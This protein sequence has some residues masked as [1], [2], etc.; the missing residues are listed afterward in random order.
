MMNLYLNVIILS[1]CLFISCESKVD[2][3]CK[4]QITY[5]LLE[6]DIEKARI[7]DLRGPQPI[8]I[9]PPLLWVYLHDKYILTLDDDTVPTPYNDY[10][11]NHIDFSDEVYSELTYSD[12]RLKEYI[13]I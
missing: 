12:G 3:P 5:D 9:T 4:L 11:I 8:E 6:Q 10:F 2:S 7:F 13:Y 1:F